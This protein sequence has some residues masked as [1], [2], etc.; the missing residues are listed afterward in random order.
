MEKINQIVHDYRVRLYVWTAMVLFSAVVGIA[1]GAGAALVVGIG[2]AIIGIASSIGFLMIDT[3]MS[4][5]GL[6]VFGNNPY[7]RS[8][9]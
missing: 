1:T 4:L 6:I 2:C 3:G 8:C 7:N 5:L 9:R